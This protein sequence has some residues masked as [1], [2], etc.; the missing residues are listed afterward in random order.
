MVRLIC[1][2][3][4]VFDDLLHCQAKS[5]KT[6]VLLSVCFRKAGSV[7]P[8]LGRMGFTRG[9]MQLTCPAFWVFGFL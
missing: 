8:V 6:A 4:L 1:R 2:D 9:A 7:C 3:A 5:G